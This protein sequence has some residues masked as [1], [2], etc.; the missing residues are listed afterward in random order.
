MEVSR[1][2][3]PTKNFYQDVGLGWEYGCDVDLPRGNYSVYWQEKCRNHETPFLEKATYDIQY[4]T[5]SFPQKVSLFSNACA[6]MCIKTFLLITWNAKI[7]YK[8]KKGNIGFGLRN[9]G[10]VRLNCHLLGASWL[11]WS[12]FHCT[13]TSACHGNL[14][15]LPGYLE[16]GQW[17]GCWD[18]KI[19]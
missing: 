13:T 10:I 11:T 6:S 14:F 17:E 2:G 7:K 19:P 15:S 4:L 18:F 3:L 8:Y 16:S 12:G 9:W 1:C 5:M